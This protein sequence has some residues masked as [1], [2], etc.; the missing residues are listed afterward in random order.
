M[1]TAGLPSRFNFGF[2]IM[3]LLI[4]SGIGSPHPENPYAQKPVRLS[5]KKALGCALPL[6]QSIFRQSNTTKPFLDVTQPGSRQTLS[7]QKLASLCSIPQP[8]VAG[9]CC[10]LAV[11]S[12]Q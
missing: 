11:G 1:M 5:M 7:S 10:C 8:G 12:N 9:D 6:P 3:I 4:L 2:C